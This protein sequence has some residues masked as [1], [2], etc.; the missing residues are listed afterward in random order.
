MD[1]E[2]ETFN[3]SA[4]SLRQVVEKVKTEGKLIPKAVIAVVVFGL[5]A[6]YPKIREITDEYGL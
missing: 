1:V 4:E 3:I 5:P 2:K 6:A